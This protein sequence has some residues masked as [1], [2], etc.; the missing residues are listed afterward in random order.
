MRLTTDDLRR[1]AVRAAGGALGIALMEALA[2]PAAALLITITF[3][4]SIVLVMGAPESPPARPRAI[5]GGHVVSAFAGILCVMVLGDALWVSAV[6]VGAAI[7]AMQALDLF[8]PP[9]GINPV[10]IAIAHATPHFVLFPVAT[11]AVIL[12]AYA[13]ADHRLTEKERWPASWL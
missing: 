8:H 6:G 2:S 7:A 11:G 4:T 3:A 12:I 1:I 5:L 9:A 13:W 10:I